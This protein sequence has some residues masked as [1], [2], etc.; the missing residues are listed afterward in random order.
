MPEEGQIM[1]KFWIGE[2]TPPD[3]GRSTAAAKPSF[4]IAKKII[5]TVV[6]DIDKIPDDIIAARFDC[7][8]QPNA[9]EAFKHVMWWMDTERRLKN[10]F[11]K[12]E[13]AKIE[14]PTLAI[15]GAN[16][17]VFVP[18]GQGCVDAMPNCRGVIVEGASHWPN[19]EDPGSFNRLAVEFLAS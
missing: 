12:E 6:A 10:T 13:L 5:S 18:Y 1:Y 9:P 14:N 7:A 17:P 16:D 19:Y 3:D 15:V 11:T 4:E 8:R 2:E